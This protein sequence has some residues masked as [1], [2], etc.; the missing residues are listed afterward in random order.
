MLTLS[1][2]VLLAGLT[3]GA[4]WG[5]LASVQTR[6]NATRI[7]ALLR[8]ARAEAANTGRRLRI[9]FDDETTQPIVSF[10]P[11]GLAEPNVFL[12]YEAWWVRRARLEASVVVESCRRTGASD[13]EV[14]DPVGLEPSDDEDALSD[15]D[16]YPDGSSDSAR[17]VLARYVEDGPAWKMEITLNG[18]DG[19][20]AQ[21][22]I[23][24]DEEGN[25]IEQDDD[26]PSSPAAG[27]EGR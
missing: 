27:P 12:P 3:V 4:M 11:D 25:E 18:I 19:T 26:A 21:R 15:V 2:I 22:R 8:A 7:A 24:L 10:E 13:F 17:I 23:P 14:I 16:F 9:S 20:V 1:L 5:T 6:E